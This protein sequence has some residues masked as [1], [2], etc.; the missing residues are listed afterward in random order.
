MFGKRSFVGGDI[1]IEQVMSE[2]VAGVAEA[3]NIVGVGNEVGSGVNGDNVMGVCCGGY[4]LTI[5][6]VVV[7]V[8]TKRIETRAAVPNAVCSSACLVPSMGMVFIAHQPN[9]TVLSGR[10]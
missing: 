1:G 9:Q 4:D 7:I 5:Y 8:D 3:D 2:L 10:R 6:R